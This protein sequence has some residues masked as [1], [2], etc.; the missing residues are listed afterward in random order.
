MFLYIILG[1]HAMSYLVD[2]M[3]FSVPGE[4]YLLLG[5]C[6]VSKWNFSGFGSALLE[7]VNLP[8]G[9]RICHVV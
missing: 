7:L 1:N 8:T 5:E 3:A 9:L 6:G 4:V 2:W